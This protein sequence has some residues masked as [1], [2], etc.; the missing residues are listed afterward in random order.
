MQSVVVALA[1]S[2]AAA[3]V[4]PSRPAARAAPLEAATISLPATV[5]PGVVTG[6]ALVDLQGL[7]EEHRGQVL[8]ATLPPL[9]NGQGTSQHQV[10]GGASEWATR[11]LASLP[12]EARSL[13]RSR[14]GAQAARA[15][16]AA[17]SARPPLRLPPVRAGNHLSRLSH[18]CT[19][20]KPCMKHKM[21]KL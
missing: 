21:Y 18:E 9:P 7:L 12:E 11:T 20:L 6:E 15:L 2:S 8:P 5:K 13:Y 17:L 10:F 1:L 19:A 14:H 16:A 4:A 3:L